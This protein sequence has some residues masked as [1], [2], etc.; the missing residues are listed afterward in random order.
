[1]VP[2]E[3]AIKKNGRYFWRF[4]DDVLL[5]EVIVGALCKL[6]DDQLSQ[7]LGKRAKLVDFTKAR[8]AFKK[9]RVVV[10]QRGFH[11]PRRQTG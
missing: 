3:Q 8:L 7:L 9:F 10:Q 2:L 11:N 1:M 6:G 5:R 4:G